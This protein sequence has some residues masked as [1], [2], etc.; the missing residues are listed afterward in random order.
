MATSTYIAD[1]SFTIVKDGV[2]DGT[3]ITLSGARP[4]IA[5]RIS[6]V[7]IKCLTATAIT[8]VDVTVTKNDTSTV[9]AKWGATSAMPLGGAVW[10][11]TTPINCAVNDNA[12]ITFTL[13]G[14]SA[15]SVAVQANW[16]LST[17]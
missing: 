12:V 2:G 14:A 8:V 9:I 11:F 3:S 5:Q 10:S 15:A 6:S 17:A 7:A 1:D 4:G 13:T 16:T